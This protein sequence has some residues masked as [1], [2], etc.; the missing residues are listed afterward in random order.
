MSVTIKPTGESFL[1]QSVEEMICHKTTA[2]PPAIPSGHLTSASEFQPINDEPSLA[3]RSHCLFT[4]MAL[5]REPFYSATIIL[6]ASD[7]S[8]TMEWHVS[9]SASLHAV[10]KQTLCG[11]N[12]SLFAGSFSRC[13]FFM[14]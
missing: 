5:S 10:C 9:D 1:E 14:L 7:D 12:G 2:K 4:S 3:S 6:N 13:H 8:L 11:V